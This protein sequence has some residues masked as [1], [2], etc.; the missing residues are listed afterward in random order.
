MA[1]ASQEV[2]EALL[3]VARKDASF[4]KGQGGKGHGHGRGRKPTVRRWTI[5]LACLAGNGYCACNAKESDS[6]KECWSLHCR[7]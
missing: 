4:R 1:A 2:P 6:C 5:I 7:A 3:A